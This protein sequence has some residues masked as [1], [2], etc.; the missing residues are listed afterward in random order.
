MYV[1]N[2]YT[3]Q[4]ALY[5]VKYGVKNLNNNNEAKNDKWLELKPTYFDYRN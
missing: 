2:I 4:L 5:T 3:L 1:M